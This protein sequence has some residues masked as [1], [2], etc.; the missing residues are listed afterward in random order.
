MCVP[1]NLISFVSLLTDLRSQGHQNGSCSYQSHSSTNKLTQ[2]SP[3]LTFPYEATLS[4]STIS[5]KQWIFPPSRLECSSSL[6]PTSLYRHHHPINPHRH[7]SNASCNN[8]NSDLIQQTGPNDVGRRL[9]LFL[10]SRFFPNI[11]FIVF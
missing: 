7:S 3:T 11:I 2:L 6:P 5:N 4:Q 8:R 1:A 9:F 10:S